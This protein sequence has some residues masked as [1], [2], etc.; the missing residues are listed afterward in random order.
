MT[1]DGV[2]DGPVPK[3]ADVFGRVGIDFEVPDSVI[4]AEAAGQND[5]QEQS[6][7]TRQGSGDLIP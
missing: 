4:E 3:R 6:P 5:R 1:G 2:N 7:R